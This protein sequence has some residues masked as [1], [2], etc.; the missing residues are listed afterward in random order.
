VLDTHP[1]TGRQW[2]VTALGAHFGGSLDAVAIGL[3]EAPRTW[4]VVEF[5]THSAKSFATLK[6]E[7][8]ERSMPQHWAQMQVYMHLTGI[9]RA[10][11]VAVCKDTDEIH[12]ERV[13]AD[14]EEGRRLIAKAKRVI[15]APRPSAKIAD[16]PAWWQCRLCEHHNHCHGNRPAERNCRTC[17]HST[18]VEGGWICE[19][20]SRELSVDEQ[21]RG[22]PFHLFIP[23]L[24]PGVPIDAGDDWVAYR[25]TVGSI[26]I[27]SA[28]S[29][30]RPATAEKPPWTSPPTRGFMA[31]K[32]K[33]DEGHE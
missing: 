28:G 21:R 14:P 6:R 4:H 30:S 5:K 10:M 1:E 23:D 22:C 26:W 8:V 24:V 15:D 32:N 19:R 13:R 29:A 18:P 31:G 20:W 3:L 16:D 27:D 17:L 7:G 33:P 25:L 12:I 11:Y 9:T 2:Q